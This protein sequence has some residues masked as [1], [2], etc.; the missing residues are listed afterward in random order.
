[1]KSPENVC[2]KYNS[3]NNHDNGDLVRFWVENVIYIENG[4]KKKIK[5]IEIKCLPLFF[6]CI[7]KRLIF[8]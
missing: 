4:E 5:E 1:M 7:I 8:N 6:L 2:Q 3:H